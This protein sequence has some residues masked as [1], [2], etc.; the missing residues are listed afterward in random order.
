MCDGRGVV[1][2]PHAHA[3]T[4]NKPFKIVCWSTTIT[5]ARLPITRTRTNKTKTDYNFAVP[6]EAWDENGNQ[7]H[8]R[9]RAAGQPFFSTS[10]MV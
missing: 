3:H 9:N 7:G 1:F 4:A 5:H 8:W 2:I 10:A 6:K